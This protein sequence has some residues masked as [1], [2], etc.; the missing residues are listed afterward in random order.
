MRATVNISQHSQILH[1]PLAVILLHRKYVALH[2]LSPTITPTRHK[3]NVLTHTRTISFN[4]MFIL[5]CNVC[6]RDKIK[7]DKRKYGTKTF[8]YN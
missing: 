6:V 3:C 5:Q 8:Q 1:A 2:M 7:R 4:V